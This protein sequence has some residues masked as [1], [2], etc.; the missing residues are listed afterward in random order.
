MTLAG[1]GPQGPVAP[2]RLQ[3]R[4]WPGTPNSPK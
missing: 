4:P 2:R 3:P 1:L